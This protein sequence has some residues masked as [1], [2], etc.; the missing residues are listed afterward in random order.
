MSGEDKEMPKPTSYIVVFEDGTYY[1]GFWYGNSHTYRKHLEDAGYQ[2][3]L[4][5]ESTILL[6]S[7]KEKELLNLN[8]PKL[9]RSFKREGNEDG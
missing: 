1:E 8:S 7:N 6:Y 2:V 5:I 4:I 3:S 9:G